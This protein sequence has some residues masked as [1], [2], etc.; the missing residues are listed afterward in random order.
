M[1]SA[2]VCRMEGRRSRQEPRGPSFR[3]LLPSLEK[4]EGHKP[5]LAAEKEAEV[6]KGDYSGDLS[7]RTYY[8]MTILI[9]LKILLETL[10]RSLEENSNNTYTNKKPKCSN[11]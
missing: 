1:P 10:C 4:V 3:R 6:E 5:G 7:N 11:T 8:D 9:S 2:V